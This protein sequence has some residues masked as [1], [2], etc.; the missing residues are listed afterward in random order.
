MGLFDDSLEK[1][2]GR[3]LAHGLGNIGG[4]LIGA[5]VAG[6]IDSATQ[7]NQPVGVPVNTS[8]NHDTNSITRNANIQVSPRGEYKV[9]KCPGCGHRSSIVDGDGTADYCE[10]CGTAIGN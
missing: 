3:G 2:I 9:V 4:A 10:Y 6:A 1:A 7:N 5:A 8:A